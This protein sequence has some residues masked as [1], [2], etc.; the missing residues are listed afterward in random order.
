MH[1]FVSLLSRRDM[2]T[3]SCAFYNHRSQFCALRLPL[4]GFSFARSITLLEE[5]LHKTERTQL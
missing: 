5:I 2:L 4:T 1:V 3:F